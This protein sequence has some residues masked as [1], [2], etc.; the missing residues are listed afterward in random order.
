MEIN[1]EITGVQELATTL[2]ALPGEV[3]DKFM[4]QALKAGAMPIR[5]RATS[6]APR[7]TGA[8]GDSIT[9]SARGKTVLVGP[10][11]APRNDKGD[12]RHMRNSTVGL[13]QEKGTVNHFAGWTNQRISAS[14]ARRQRRKQII[15]VGS[16]TQRMPANPFL[17][18][19]LEEGAQEAFQAEADKLRELIETKFRKE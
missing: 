1:L 3:Q 15:T 9:I 14:Q 17:K 4:I 12:E 19:A 13:F 6:N 7:D 2:R 16:T 10:S 5:D 11:T 18:R 8:L